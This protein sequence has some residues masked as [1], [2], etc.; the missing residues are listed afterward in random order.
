MRARLLGE[1]VGVSPH[2][3]RGVETLLLGD[4]VLRVVATHHAVGPVEDLVPVLDR[5]THQLGDDDERELGG[6]QRDEVAFALRQRL[7]D[8]V[9]A[10]LLDALLEPGDH[11]G[12]E[13]AV[14]QLA[15][16]GVV[17]R[18]L[19]EHEQT[20]VVDLLL[21][22]LV[23]HRRLLVRR[24]QLGVAGHVDHVRVPGEG[25]VALGEL[26]I[27]VPEDRLLGPQP[28]QL[29]VRD[30]GLGVLI[31]VIEV[32]LVALRHSSAPFFSATR[33]GTS[34]PGGRT[35]SNLARI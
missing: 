17:G 10:R 31:H 2:L 14:H 27:V 35:S 12:S 34:L 16:S 9:V 24:E 32:D 8:D 33:L 23:E 22:V 28:L 15:G 11:P 29:G 1:L 7:P 26:R 30:A 6:A 19:V 4:A 5:H 20:L 21:R 18:V 13:T 3:L 25:P